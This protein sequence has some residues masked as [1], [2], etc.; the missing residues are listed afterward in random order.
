MT[1]QEAQA[2]ID[3]IYANKEHPFHR[4][5]KVAMKRMLELVAAANPGS[6]TDISELRATG[7][8]FTGT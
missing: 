2:K 5:D 1:P 7:F 8:E 4:G 3:E 6:S